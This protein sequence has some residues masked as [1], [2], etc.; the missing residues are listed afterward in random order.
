M[1]DN[2]PVLG[3]YGKLP[4]Q[5]MIRTYWNGRIHVTIKTYW[6][7]GIHVVFFKFSA[8]MI[9]TIHWKKFINTIPKPLFVNVTVL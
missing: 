4:A 9:I 7:G 5:F 3:N 8:G 6:N 2:F 1:F